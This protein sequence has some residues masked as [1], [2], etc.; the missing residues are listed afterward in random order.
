MYRHVHYTC[1]CIYI[2]MYVIIIP[3]IKRFKNK[4]MTESNFSKTSGTGIIG[5]GKQIV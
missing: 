1:I 5:H 2:Y 3:L 4:K